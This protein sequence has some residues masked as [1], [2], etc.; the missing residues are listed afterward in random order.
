MIHR[1]P[2]LKRLL[3]SAM[4]M[5]K[6]LF[7]LANLKAFPGYIRFITDLRKY[8]KMGGTALAGDFWPCL[9]DK[10]ATTGI[11][12]HYFHQAV[13]AGHKIQEFS[14]ADHVDIGSDVC[15]VGMLTTILPVRFVDIR[16]LQLNIPNYEGIDGSILDLPF[17]DASINSISCLHVIEHIGLGR[18]GD[19][20]DPEGSI[21]ACRELQRVLAPCGQLLVS[22]P[23][24][25]ARVQFNGQRV[26]AVRDVLQM[27]PELTLTEMAMVDAAGSFHATLL[28]DDQRISALEQ[29][30]ADFGLGLFLFT[31]QGDTH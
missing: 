22:M 12:A 30:T 11:D 31:R 9:F 28:P 23:I 18:Y 14:P 24:G 29:A 5:M 4:R 15:Y 13:W 6:P 3:L 7:S 19:P 10:T 16:P 21:K 26:F 20:L 25:T 27:F 2:S 1:T 8:R 17:P